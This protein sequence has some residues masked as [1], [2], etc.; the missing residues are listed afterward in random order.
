MWKI[1]E[2]LK[3]SV[4]SMI[5]SYYAKGHH[6]WLLEFIRFNIYSFYLWKEGFYLD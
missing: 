3:Y 6:K 2:S 4:S 1:E 5:E